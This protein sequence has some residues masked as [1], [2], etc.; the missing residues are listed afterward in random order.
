MKYSY[1]ISEEIV[2]WSFEVFIKNNFEELRWWIAF[3]NPTAGPWKTI[4]AIDDKGFSHEVYR[5]TRDEDRPDLVLVNDVKKTILVIEAKDY[6]DKLCD[7]RQMEKS[8]KVIVKM[9]ETLQGITNTM[10][11]SRKNYSFVPS[12]LWYTSN[13]QSCAEENTMVTNLFD[14]VK[15]TLPVVKNQSVV[16]III[17]KN[18]EIMSP[19]FFYKG[20]SSPEFKVP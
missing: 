17:Y 3:T 1:S 20:K 8:L 10:W 14:Q 16:N 13:S 7:R 11:E 9:Q 4:I 2:R 12:F 5:F 18:G 15:I 19:H 6:C